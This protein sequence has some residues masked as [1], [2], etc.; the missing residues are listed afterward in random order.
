MMKEK[1]I[2]EFFLKRSNVCS[3]QPPAESLASIA[4]NNILL[5]VL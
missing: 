1:G 4:K 3:G 2:F 5:V